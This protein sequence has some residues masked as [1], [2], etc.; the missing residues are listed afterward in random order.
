[1]VGTP[2]KLGQR[3][4]PLTTSPASVPAR[5]SGSP[6]GNAVEPSCVVAVN[7]DCTTCPPL[8]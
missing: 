3:V 5:T 8:A 7:N 1:M 4:S 2:G 6:A